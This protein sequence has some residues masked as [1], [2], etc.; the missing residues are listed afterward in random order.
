[1]N[2]EFL[3][4]QKL[5]G[6]ITENQ[7]KQLNENLLSMLKDYVSDH[8]TADQGWGEDQEEAEENLKQSETEIINLK[9]QEYFENLKEF[10]SLVTYD[11][12]YAGPE[13][14]EEIQPQLEE[15][16]NKLG[17]SVDQLRYN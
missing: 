10:A 6:L 14:S 8:Y 3:K 7:F 2:K 13:E 17:F 9:G 15:L 16:A 11:N 12:E 4:M 5:A 1:M